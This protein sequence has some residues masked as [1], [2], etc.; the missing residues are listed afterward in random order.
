MK[1]HIFLLIYLTTLLVQSS[2]AQKPISLNFTGKVDFGHKHGYSS[3]PTIAN[4]STDLFCNVHDIT[5]NG[6]LT[7]TTLSTILIDRPNITSKLRPNANA[8]TAP[9]DCAQILYNNGFK[10]VS[11]SNSHIGAY[12]FE[13][14][15]STSDALRRNSIMFAGIRSFCESTIITHNG[16]KI[17][18][19]SFGNTAYTPSIND[20]VKIA[21]TAMRLDSV[22]DIVV[23]AYSIDKQGSLYTP[24]QASTKAK[25]QHHR[26]AE[27]FAKTAID[28]GADIVYGDGENTPQ[29]LQL[30]KEKLVI[31]GLGNFCTPSQ[32][33]FN[34]ENGS[35]PIITVNIYPNGTFRDAQI[36]SFRQSPAHGPMA[37]IEKNALR[38]IKEKTLSINPD[39]TLAIN[40][41]GLVLPTVKSSTTLAIEVLAEGHTHLGK[42]YRRGANG[43]DIFDCSGFTSYIFRK[44]G[45]ELQRT[46]AAQYLQGKHV[47]KDELM[48][49]DLV[50]FKGS[51][52]RRIGH[53]GVVVSVDKD[54]KTFTFI[55]ASNRGVIVDNFAKS[56]YYIPRYVG[57]TRVIGNIDK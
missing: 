28:S 53:V 34:T 20:S 22:C 54:N 14:L 26:L 41:E 56:S 33:K 19:A 13:G 12:G 31:Y 6:N 15:A 30:Y 38:V 29:A 46:T 16:I 39:S 47:S 51:A 49:G 10:G 11:A 35:A 17:G 24:M 21:Q 48:P 1:R 32:S 55:H 5:N 37:D 25:S 43:P 4:D 50:F 40:D 42:R 57:A 7:F 3:N 23:M 18:F 2:V 27:K 44:I 52:S 9:S 45:I 36:H 8:S